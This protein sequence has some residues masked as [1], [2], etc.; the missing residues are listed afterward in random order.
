VNGLKYGIVNGLVFAP[1]GFFG[2]VYLAEFSQYNI[3]FSFSMA[4]GLGLAS[5]WAFALNGALLQ[6]GSACIQHFFLRLV[7]CLK[8]FIP[9]DYAKFLDFAS[10]RLLMKKVGGGYI[11]FHRMLMEHFDQ[12]S[13]VN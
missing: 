4:L 2:V 3:S 10:D 12:T 1:T 9:W 6:G 11:F 7:L 5:F 13:S 8:D